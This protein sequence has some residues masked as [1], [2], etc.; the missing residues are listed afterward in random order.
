[1]ANNIPSIQD[2]YNQYIDS[3]KASNVKLNTNFTGTVVDIFGNAYSSI[4]FSLYQYLFTINQGN[5]IFTAGEF[6]LNTYTQELGISQ[7]KT[8][9]VAS[10]DLLITLKTGTTTLKIPANSEFNIGNIRYSSVQDTTIDENNNLV[11]VAANQ[12]GAE[13]NLKSGASLQSNIQGIETA[14]SQGIFGGNGLETLAQLRQRILDNI[15]FRRTSSQL[16][17][18]VQFCLEYFN[19]CVASTTFLNDVIPI[20][21]DCLIVNTIQDFDVAAENTVINEIECSADQLAF[22]L[23]VLNNQK[24]T[25][26]LPK[27]STTTTQVIPSLEITVQKL[28]NDETPDSVLIDKVKKQVRKAVLLYNRDSFFAAG[29]DLTSLNEIV[30][31]FF[32]TPF[33]P[34]DVTSPQLDLLLSNI[35]VNIDV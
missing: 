29:L 28:D 6:M 17:D 3:V 5:N 33:T 13:Y 14:I 31:S 19:Y 18:Y 35:T 25:D 4:T 9:T 32:I 34:I 16:S 10:G 23:G 7:R 12:A 21:V 27:T 22:M 2:I 11:T 30:K 24:S 26:V 20:G 1:M 15:Q 8:G